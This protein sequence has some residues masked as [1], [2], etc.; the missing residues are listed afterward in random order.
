MLL[1]KQYINIIQLA[2]IIVQINNT[3]MIIA[4]IDNINVIV[5]INSINMIIAMINS[6][7]II[8]IIKFYSAYKSVNSR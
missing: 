4:I 6:I 1:N 3:N 5:Q 7:I 8:I 2:E